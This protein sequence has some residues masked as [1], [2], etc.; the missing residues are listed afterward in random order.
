MTKI[1]CFKFSLSKPT[2][3]EYFIISLT[4]SILF[5]YLYKIYSKIDFRSLYHK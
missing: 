4:S 2:S 1:I 3:F 5:I